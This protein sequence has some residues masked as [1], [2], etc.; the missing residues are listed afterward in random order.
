MTNEEY[1]TKLNAIEQLLEELKAVLP[2][3]PPCGR[4]VYDCDPA[5]HTEVEL[6]DEALSTVSA[7]GCPL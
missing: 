7:M 4:Y 3:H 2:T 6:I 5:L 1:G